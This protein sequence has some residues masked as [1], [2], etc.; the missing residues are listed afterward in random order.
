MVGRWSPGVTRGSNRKEARWKNR[1][2]SLPTEGE[3]LSFYA[4]S[5]EA[6]RHAV[7]TRVCEVGKKRTGT[8]AT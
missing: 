6:E 1:S 2:L 3:T 8:E 4:R 5:C 7:D